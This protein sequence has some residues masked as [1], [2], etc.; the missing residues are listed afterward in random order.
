MSHASQPIE[1]I[2]QRAG[3]RDHRHRELGCAQAAG[4]GIQAQQS[5]RR[6]GEE[7]GDAAGQP[8][9][10][11]DLDERAVALLGGR[12]LSRPPLLGQPRSEPEDRELP[13]VSGLGEHRLD[14]VGL[15][16]KRGVV[17]HDPEVADP[18]A[19][20]DGTDH[21]GADQ[22]DNRHERVEDRDHD[23]ER[24]R[25]KDPEDEPELSDR[26]SARSATAP[27]HRT[28]VTGP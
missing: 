7:E 2:P 22:G 13:G 28:R 9:L 11:R 26:G 27:G 17:V 4:G 6:D 8:L 23:P 15:T 20:H 12:D 25:G 10:L 3:D 14:V 24:H 21:E 1:D 19:A 16:T 5:E 18:F